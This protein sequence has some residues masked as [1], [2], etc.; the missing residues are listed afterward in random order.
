MTPNLS[1][2]KVKSLIS[3]IILL[4]DH[5]KSCVIY[6]YGILDRLLEKTV[7]IARKQFSGSDCEINICPR[8][9]FSRSA[10]AQGILVQS[11]LA[12]SCIKP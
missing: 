11:G 6:R 7:K 5:E 2:S 10:S 4:F 3:F 9:S 8:F 1:M 12:Y